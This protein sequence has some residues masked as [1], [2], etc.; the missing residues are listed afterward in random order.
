MTLREEGALSA[1]TSGS[2]LLQRKVSTHQT[3]SPAASC[4]RHS[5]GKNVFSRMNSVSRPIESQRESACAS[6]A[7]SSSRSI[8]ITSG[9]P[10]IQYNLKIHYD[11]I[12]RCCD[13]QKRFW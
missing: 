12:E 10:S 7:S 4:S 13:L 9:M 5:P 3:L 8:Q 11:R 2:R 6:C 1:G